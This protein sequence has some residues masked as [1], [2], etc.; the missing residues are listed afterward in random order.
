MAADGD[1]VTDAERLIDLNR[2]A[3]KRVAERVLERKAGNRG[4]DRRA[5]QDVEARDVEDDEAGGEDEQDHHR[6]LHDRWCTVGDLVL[7]PGVEQQRDEQV[8]Q[9]ERNE[10]PLETQAGDPGKP[11]VG[12]L[13]H[14][15][16]ERDGERRAAAC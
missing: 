10:Q 11:G 3:G 2:D 5:R 7:V 16:V 6:V 15:E 14:D 4:D 13:Q 1:P 12:V 8:D 9:R